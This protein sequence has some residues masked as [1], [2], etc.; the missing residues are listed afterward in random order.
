MT[1]GNQLEGVSVC[2][3]HNREVSMVQGRERR[4]ARPLG[5]GDDRGVDETESEIVVRPDQ[6]ETSFVVA[7]DEVDDVKAVAGDEP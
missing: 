2:R 3:S 1:S 6:F 7:R 5:N 4:L